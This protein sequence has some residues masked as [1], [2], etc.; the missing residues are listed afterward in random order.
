MF[1]LKESVHAG[2][3]I[4]CQKGRRALAGVAGAHPA[5]HH[6][7][8]ARLPSSARLVQAALQNFTSRPQ[9]WASL[10]LTSRSRQVHK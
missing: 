3:L 6:P 7:A 9:A 4:G 1:T 8:S 2:M 5:Q 10:I